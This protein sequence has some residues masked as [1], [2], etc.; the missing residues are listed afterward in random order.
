MN[1]S[2]SPL[3][4]LTCISDDEKSGFAIDVVGASWQIF[5]I[6]HPNWTVRESASL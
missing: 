1:L 3:F 6:P 5:K 4:K 2:L